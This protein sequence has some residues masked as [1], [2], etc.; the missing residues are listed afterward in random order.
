MT[1]RAFADAS[2]SPS[3]SPTSITGVHRL[4]RSLHHVLGAA[5]TP[6][7][8]PRRRGRDRP[9]VGRRDGL[10]AEQARWP[11]APRR[12]PPAPDATVA[13]PVGDRPAGAASAGS[14]H[15]VLD[16]VDTPPTQPR[17]RGPI[18]PAVQ[19]RDGLDAERA[20]WPRALGDPRHHAEPPSP[21]WPTTGE[22]PRSRCVQAGGQPGQ[23]GRRTASRIATTSTRP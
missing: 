11:R 19:R 3:P 6:P 2:R 23:P 21:S 22:Q 4:G 20:R 15:H 18:Y 1:R 17:S 9:A 16:A 12:S 10:E 14:L 8:Q 5:D 13:D 7:M